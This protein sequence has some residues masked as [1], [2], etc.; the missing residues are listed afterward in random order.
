MWKP[1]FSSSYSGSRGLTSYEAPN[2]HNVFL[3]IHSYIG[4]SICYVSRLV[5]GAQETDYHVLENPWSSRGQC[6]IGCHGGVTGSSEKGGS[7]CLGYQEGFPEEVAPELCFAMDI[8]FTS[9]DGDREGIPGRR[10]SMSND[11]RR[12][13][14]REGR[15]GRQR[16]EVGPHSIIGNVTELSRGPDV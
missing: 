6:A 5:A 13:V 7:H 11:E 16:K 1:S 14:M 8:G 12:A 2:F 10:N 9:R 15:R 3:F 4:Q